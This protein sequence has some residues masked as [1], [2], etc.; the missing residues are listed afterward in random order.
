MAK[1]YTNRVY[2]TTTTTGTGAITMAGA[3]A[4]FFTWAAKVASGSTVDYVIVSS[5]GTGLA[6]VEVGRGTWT[7]TLSRDTVLQSS[8]AGALVNFSA[9]S[10][11]VFLTV[12]AE[13]LPYLDMANTFT[14]PVNASAITVATQTHTASAPA[15]NMAQ[16]WNNVAVA[17]T[18]EFTNVTNT[19]SAAGSL[20]KDMQ[21]GGVSQWNCSKGGATAQLGV[22]IGP[23]GASGAPTYSFAGSATTGLYSRATNTTAITCNST[24]VMEWTATLCRMKSNISLQWFSGTLAAGVADT[25][26]SR[27]S[28]G[29]IGVGT[30]VA[31]SFAGDLKLRQLY[32]DFTNTA[33]VGA[34]TINKS[35]GQ[36]ILAA[37]AA[38][39]VVTNSLVTVNSQVF[40]TI[41]QNDATA[42]IKNV[43]A[44]TG[45]FTVT[46][47]AAATANCAINFLVMNQ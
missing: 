38:A 30:G 43:V 32:P 13:D 4:G 40:C 9:G 7:T 19:A 2:E 37:A 44:A 8:N 25:G 1:L 14:P 45:S 34:V 22:C 23:L 12:V 33:T 27:I 16:T 26:L 5:A 20:L 28:A 3:V 36:C 46:A 31:G 39:V 18:A 11:D 17:F 29:L 35:C 21:V 41:A 42:T 10:K 47:T 24:D 15:W 6:E